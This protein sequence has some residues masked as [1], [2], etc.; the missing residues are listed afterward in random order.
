[1]NKEQII[2]DYGSL[3]LAYVGD[4][5]YEILVRE[6]ILSKGITVNGQMHLAAKRYVSAAAQCE[7]LSKLTE[8]LT[9]DELGV[10]RRGRNAKSHSHPKN[11]D[12]ADYHRATSFEALIGYLFV[13]ERR[14]RMEE[15]INA[16]LDG[17]ENN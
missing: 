10:V 8:F 2:R 5:V 6:H 13:K 17:V 4:A 14:E 3:S 16:V 9:E 11:A 1:M 12:L 7:L 15:L